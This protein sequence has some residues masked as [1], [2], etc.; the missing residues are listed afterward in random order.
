MFL[1]FDVGLEVGETI[2]VVLGVLI[3]VVG[4]LV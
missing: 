4:G 1:G 3:V 2:E